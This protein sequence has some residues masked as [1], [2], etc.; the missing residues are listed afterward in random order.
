[1]LYV[2]VGI[3]ENYSSKDGFIRSIDSVFDLLF[4]NEWIIGQSLSHKK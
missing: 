2:Y 1:M 4:E 3:M